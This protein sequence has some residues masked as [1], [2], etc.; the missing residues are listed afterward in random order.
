MSKFVGAEFQTFVI[1][2]NASFLMME[3]IR[4]EKPTRIR[5]VFYA[6]ETDETTQVS[7]V[8]MDENMDVLFSNHNSHKALIDFE[9]SIVGDAEYSFLFKNESPGDRIIVFGLHTEET[10]KSYQL[11]E[12]DLDKNGVIVERFNQDRED[13]ILYGDVPDDMSAAADANLVVDG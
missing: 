9:T 7:C 13:E 11:P 8:V 6:Y 10:E 2:E 3:R 4:Y 12:W 1:A 5:G